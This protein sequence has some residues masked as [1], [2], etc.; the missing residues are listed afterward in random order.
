MS[1][2]NSLPERALQ[3]ASSVSDNVRHAVPAAGRWLE[4][5]AK[6]GVLK[7]GAKAAGAFVR[8]NPVITAAAVAGAGLLWYAAHRRA[9]RIQNGENDA[10][11]EGSAKRVEA[12]RG[13]G[14]QRAAPRRRSSSKAASE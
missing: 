4:T 8:R 9:K 13:N 6:L 3:L 10:A 14:S 2:L 12:R 1:K 11:I 5:G 7:T